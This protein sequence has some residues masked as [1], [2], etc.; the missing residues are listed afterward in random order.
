ME[1]G[2]CKIGAGHKSRRGR[3]P[4]LGGEEGWDRADL[5]NNGAVGG[6]RGS[7]GWLGPA[8]TWAVME[9]WERGSAPVM[10]Q[11]RQAAGP[12]GLRA[13]PGSYQL[14]S[15]GGAGAL[16]GDT[17]AEAGQAAVR[18]AGACRKWWAGTGCR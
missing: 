12:P 2:A 8:L 9:A 10:S 13:R 3:R 14:V 17:H 7:A 1:N 16:L 11:E 4:C 5:S 15:A 6:P 18:V